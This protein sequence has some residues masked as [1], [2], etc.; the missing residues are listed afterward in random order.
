M[1]LVFSVSDDADIFQT[2]RGRWSA[3]V[4]YGGVAEAPTAGVTSKINCTQMSEARR[5]LVALC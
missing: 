4:Y 3:N 1:D 5:A 2:W